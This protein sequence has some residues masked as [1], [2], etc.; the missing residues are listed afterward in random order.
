MTQAIMTSPRVRALAVAAAAAVLTGILSVPALA[1]ESRIGV[2]SAVNPEAEGRPPGAAMRVLQVGIDLQADERVTTSA[3][4]QAQLLFLDGS[5]MS[6]GPNSDLV[7][8]RFVY[9]PGTRQG[10]LAVRLGRGVLRIVGGRISKTNAIRV[11]TD[12]ATMGI[13]GGIGT[14]EVGANG[15]VTAGFLFGDGLTVTSQGIT[16][17]TDIPGSIIET[18]PGAPPEPPRIMTGTEVSSTLAVFEGP[19]PAEAQ[20]PASGDGAGA[21][22]AGNPDAALQSANLSNE[23]AAPP[24]PAPPPAG[25]AGT[26]L[27]AETERTR[28]DLPPTLAVVLDPDDDPV[29]DQE[30][31]G[32]EAAGEGEGEP[33][34]DLDTIIDDVA[35]DVNDDAPVEEPPVEQPADAVALS[36]DGRLLR[37]PAF[38]SFDAVTGAAPFGAANTPELASVS[39]GA[40][41]LSATTVTG[42]AYR[43]PYQA[44][45]VEYAVSDGNSTGPFDSFSGRMFVAADGSFWRVGGRAAAG[46]ADAG[47]GFL[48]FAGTQTP[49]AQIPTAGTVALGVGGLLDPLPFTGGDTPFGTQTA[50]TAVSPLFLRYGPGITAAQRDTGLAPPAGFQVFLQV[51]GSGAAQRSMMAGSLV[52]LVEEGQA[53]SGRPALAGSFLGSRRDAA[54]AAP[55]A[56]AGSI[57]S[58]ATDA[59][60]ALYGSSGQYMV[61]D[62]SALTRDSAGSVNRQSAAVSVSALDGA[63]PEGGWFSLTVQ[64]GANVPPGYFGSRTSRTMRGFTGG[65]GA[66]RAADGT[67]T[68][69]AVVN[70]PGEVAPGGILVAT[71]ATSGTVSA[72]LK[73][74]RRDNGA[75]RTLYLGGEAGPSALAPAGVFIDNGRYA[76]R[77]AAQPVADGAGIQAQ[78]QALLL[79]TGE[80]I[81]PA[82][83]WP[84]VQACRCEYLDWGFWSGSVDWA[85]GS[86]ERYHMANWVAGELPELVQIPSTGSASYAGQILGGVING[87]QSYLASGD[88]DV[89]W[90]F[91]ARSGSMQVTGFDAA[92]YAG[93]LSSTDGR[94][95]VGSAESIAA[96]RT[97][98]ID[99]S[100]FSGGGDPVAA[101][102]GS[103]TVQGAAGGYDAAGVWMLDRTN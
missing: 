101:M 69:F 88:M 38:D 46:S 20:A 94:Q 97:M 62:P 10:E 14:F 64:P 13:R 15:N 54:G 86:Q 78:G 6:I 28:P 65:I 66:A 24:P 90:N 19:P 95:I 11:E 72:E 7:L 103:F 82:T 41:E 32:E 27:H 102:G 91:G 85:D 33:G 2:A 3:N 31:V 92:D 35:D 89:A 36:D 60:S 40:G 48:L 81:N 87:A 77:E 100:L 59:G 34:S 53:G 61:L 17:S 12:S 50:G 70:D 29:A 68:S 74:A 76:A 58:S 44:N 49:L 67:V 93:S 98:S 71:D 4:G 39:V 8:D 52:S 79:V 96:A 18:L 80:S 22:A 42:E 47:N 21:P 83:L 99:G 55:V 75:I 16:Q 9:D 84:G 1:V 25:T 56:L 5:A 37:M 26:A 30:P 73:I 51:D 63:E 43:F 45:G 23:G 57:A